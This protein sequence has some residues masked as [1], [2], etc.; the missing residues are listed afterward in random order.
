MPK[1]EVTDGYGVPCSSEAGD[2]VVTN[3]ANSQPDFN[4]A[5]APTQQPP[6][7]ATPQPALPSAMPATPLSQ[8]PPAVGSSTVFLVVP[9]S[10]ADFG[11]AVLASM[12]GELATR[13]GV[14]AAEVII[15]VFAGSVVLSVTLPQAASDSLEQDAKT[16][17]FR[18]GNSKILAVYSSSAQA[19]AFAKQATAAGDSVKTNP[20]Q[21]VDAAVDPPPAATSG[22]PRVHGS[23]SQSGIMAFVV[24]LPVLCIVARH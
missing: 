18:L 21:P 11:A 6:P 12:K 13:Y 5:P 19:T 8:S 15:E 22:T 14:P 2:V 9:G 24:L 23:L 20:L 3:C 1:V 16:P 7:A 10:L 17:N 4:P